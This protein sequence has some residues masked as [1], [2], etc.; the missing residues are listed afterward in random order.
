MAEDGIEDSVRGSEQKDFRALDETCSQCMSFALVAQLVQDSVEILY[1]Q[2]QPSTAR[3]ALVHECR[4]GISGEA[5]LIAFVPGQRI[6][7]V[8]PLG[9]VRGAGQV[10]QGGEPEIRQIP[11]P[12][13]FLV[14]R[15]RLP[16]GGKLRTL[17]DCVQEAQPEGGL[18]HA[19]RADEHHVLAWPARRLFPKEA[20]HLRERVLAGNER[21]L[22]LVRGQLGGVVEAPANHGAICLP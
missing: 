14:E 6:S 20:E 3:L 17:R 9:I 21:R 12:V 19:A 18:S 22:Q 2:N 5:F 15:D 13:A 16:D 4:E 11:D 8:G 10:A 7:L 1:E